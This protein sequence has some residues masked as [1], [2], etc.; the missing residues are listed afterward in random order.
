M[1]GTSFVNEPVSSAPIGGPGVPGKQ[2]YVPPEPDTWV[3]LAYIQSQRGNGNQQASS[4]YQARQTPPQQHLDQACAK[5]NN[6]K[7]LNQKCPSCV[8]IN[9][10]NMSRLLNKLAAFSRISFVQATKKHHHSIHV[11]LET[12]IYDLSKIN[13][14]FGIKTNG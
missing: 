3:S 7:S 14:Q 10:K 8:M 6:S 1:L 12:F 11:S 5:L 9:C 2:N 13:R 4:E